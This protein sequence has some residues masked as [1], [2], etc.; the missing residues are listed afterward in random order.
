RREWWAR[1]AL[2]TLRF[3]TSPALPE[4][5]FQHRRRLA[6]AKA[7]INLRRVMA[8]RRGKEAHAAFDRTALG[9]GR[10]VIESADARERD[11]AGAHGA[12]LE[13]DIEV[14]IG[15]PLRADPFGSLTYGQ[16]FRMRGRI[17][18]SQGAV[19]RGCDHLVVP[20]DHAADRHFAG[21]AGGFGRL[22]RQIHERRG[23]HASYFLPQSANSPPNPPPLSND[24]FIPPHNHK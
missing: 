20:D 13:R 15:E 18:I 2:L 4:K 1:F 6:L 11:R 8:G 14:A 12:G 16:H 21:F 3:G 24:P 17:A 23:V 9:I 22:Q 7:G 5:L 10:A 19:A